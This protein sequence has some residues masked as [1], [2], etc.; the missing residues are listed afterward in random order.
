M[1]NTNDTPIPEPILPPSTTTI[2]VKLDGSHNYLA[3]KMQ[4]LNLL[5][6]HD[7]VGFID[8][9]DAKHLASSSLNPAY[10]VWQKKHVYLLGWI[11]ASL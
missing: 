3:W 4:F 7:L 11:L 8:G 10:V 1:A 6:R 5:Q 9:T 2:S